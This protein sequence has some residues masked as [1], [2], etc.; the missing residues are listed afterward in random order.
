MAYCSVY[1]C[2]NN[3]KS[4]K[5]K[6]FFL[7]PK[8]PEVSKAWIAAIN[9]TKL[10]AKVF[11]C[12]DHFE[13]TCFDLSWKLQ[14]ELFYKDRPCKRRLIPNS[15]PTIFCHKTAPKER[16]SSTSRAKRSQS[17]DLVKSALVEDSE[18]LC[19]I[20]NEVEFEV[21]S[22]L[23]IGIQAIPKTQTSATP[24]KDTSVRSTCTQTSCS[25][26]DAQTLTQVAVNVYVFR[27]KLY[28]S[29]NSDL[30][31]VN[32]QS[33]A[34]ALN[35]TFNIL[36]KG[37]ISNT[38]KML[39]L[40]NLIEPPTSE[41]SHEGH[42]LDEDVISDG[43]NESED[44]EWLVKSLERADKSDPNYSISQEMDEGEDE[45][46][47]QERIEHRNMEPCKQKTYLVYETC[48]KEQHDV[49]KMW[50]LCDAFLILK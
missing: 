25:V 2:K 26:A 1:G 7:M 6:R 43:D 29:F 4:N 28:C 9:R 49:V 30:D 27:F 38:L 5:D 15:V 41:F 8:N 21:E 24:Y 13:E 44:D 47:E 20:D 11:L 36:H 10:P 37:N 32:L 12:S 33:A 14:N 48:I 17:K 45:E 42:D 16:S 23:S 46:Q 31:D 40:S 3:I 50:M 22:K 39:G 35:S 19:L 34:A 18:Q